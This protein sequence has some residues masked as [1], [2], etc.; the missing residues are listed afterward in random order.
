MTVAGSTPENFV[1]YDG[2]CPICASYMAIA[3][4]RRVKP[5]VA[6]LDARQEPTLVADLRRRGHAVNESILVQLGDRV[7]A[8]PA[9]T[10][11]I[12]NLGSANPVMRRSA[13]WLIGSAPWSA[14]L[15]PWLRAT[16][17][18]LLKIMGRGLVP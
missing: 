15:Y 17:N 4:L 9:A 3:A 6:V 5:D 18:L 1:L 10:R 12:A 11:L 8:G 2:A 7:F 16:R 13:L 14:A